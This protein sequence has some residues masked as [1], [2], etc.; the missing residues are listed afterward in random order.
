MSDEFRWFSY[1]TDGWYIE[2]RARDQYEAL[3]MLRGRL[4]DP[5]IRQ[6]E[7]NPCTEADES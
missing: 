3:L 7:V 2:L 5:N 1:S 4:T 6:D